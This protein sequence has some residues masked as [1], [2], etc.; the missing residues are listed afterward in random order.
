MGA[1]YGNQ[2]DEGLVRRCQDDESVLTI[3]TNVTRP[4]TYIRQIDVVSLFI[5]FSAS[6]FVLSFSGLIPVV[7]I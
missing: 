4:L 7:F 5:S 6:F 1:D 2:V 3:L